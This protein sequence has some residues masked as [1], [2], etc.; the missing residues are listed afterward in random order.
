MDA[1]IIAAVTAVLGG[2]AVAAALVVYRLWR[3][4]VHE[5]RALLMHRVLEHEGVS[6]NG[7]AHESVLARTAVAARG[8]LLCRARET[9]IAWLEGDAAMPLSRFYPN[10]DLVARLK[11]ERR[12]SSPSPG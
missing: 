8:C 7:C 4:G 11:A 3:A 12:A 9:C 2:L 5:D 1:L 6:L 10:V